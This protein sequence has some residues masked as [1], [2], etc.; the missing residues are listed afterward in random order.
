M[1]ILSLSRHELFPLC[2]RNV[3]FKRIQSFLVLWFSIYLGNIQ[4]RHMLYL[5]NIRY[6]Q[7]F[8]LFALQL[9]VW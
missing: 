1:V 3:S 4:H 6:E 2:K 5:V 9:H 7:D 8:K